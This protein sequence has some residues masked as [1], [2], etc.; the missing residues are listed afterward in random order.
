MILISDEENVLSVIVEKLF[1]QQKRKSAEKPASGNA[2]LLGLAPHTWNIF[3]NRNHVVPLSR[4]S[5][6]ISGH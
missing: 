3:L 6:G 5:L 2:L 4:T 1:P